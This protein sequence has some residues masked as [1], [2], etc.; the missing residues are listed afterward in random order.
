MNV[1]LGI[2]ANLGNRAENLK[3][4]VLRIEKYIG[5]VLGSSSVFET[6]PWGFE[7]YDQFLNMVVKVE[8]K[9]SPS[10][11]L[12]EILKIE[13]LLGRVRGEELYSS[14]LIDIDLLLYED[15]IINEKNLIVP[16][17]LMHERKFVL[18]PLCQIAPEMKHPVMKVTFAS[19]LESCNDKSSCKI[20]KP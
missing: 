6:E 12:G 16:H 17:P 1:F 19:L 4:S 14:R 11:L 20:Y 9:H 3:D 2:G 18:V 10:M 8:T 5:P 13:T 7:T 15:Q